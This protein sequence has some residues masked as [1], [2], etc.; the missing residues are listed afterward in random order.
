MPRQG[1]AQEGCAALRHEMPVMDF[2][3]PARHE[4]ER[5][6]QHTPTTDRQSIHHDADVRLMNAADDVTLK[7]APCCSAAQTR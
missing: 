6:M 3:F 4:H 5:V 2:P 1:P 7:V